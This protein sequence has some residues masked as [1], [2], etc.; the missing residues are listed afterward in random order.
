MYLFFDTETTGLP[1]SSTSNYENWPRIIQIAWLLIDEDGD[2]K[3]KNS[4]IIKPK[5]FKRSL[6]FLGGFRKYMVLQ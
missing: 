6:K 4:Y 2:I 5:E 1:Y 3:S